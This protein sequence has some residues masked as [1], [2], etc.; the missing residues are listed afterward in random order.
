MDFDRIY[1]HHRLWKW[2]RYLRVW[3]WIMI[4]FSLDNK[5]IL[6]IDWFFW[7][8]RSK[9]NN[10]SPSISNNMSAQ[11]TFILLNC[12]VLNF[13]KKWIKNLILVH[14]TAPTQ[15][16][17][18]RKCLDLIEIFFC[19]HFCLKRFHNNNYGRVKFVQLF[20]S[21]YWVID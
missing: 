8:I 3:S 2:L 13:G 4:F 16:L 11:N 7:L 12:N 20:F 19:S 9:R 5:L 10:S 15:W 1:L 21:L 17:W 18:H 14:S 6:K